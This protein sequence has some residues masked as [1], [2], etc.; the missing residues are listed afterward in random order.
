MIDKC[1]NDG[2]EYLERKIDEARI[3]GSFNDFDLGIIDAI[4]QHRQSS[5]A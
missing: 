4:Q 2:I 5:V 1:G 3:I